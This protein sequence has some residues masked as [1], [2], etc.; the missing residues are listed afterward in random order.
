MKINLDFAKHQS[1]GNVHH[2]KP[3]DNFQQ[4]ESAKK[5]YAENKTNI[6]ISILHTM[7]KGAGEIVNGT[8]ITITTGHY[9]Y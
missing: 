8:T 9:K 4:F 1:L 5:V 2:D 7:K 6:D 3:A